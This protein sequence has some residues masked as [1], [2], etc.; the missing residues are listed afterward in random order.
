MLRGN[1]CIEQAFQPNRT[2]SSSTAKAFQ[3]SIQAKLSLPLLPLLEHLP[4]PTTKTKQQRCNAAGKLAIEYHNHVGFGVSK[5]TVPVAAHTQFVR[6][7]VT[8][9]LLGSVWWIF[10]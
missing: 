6:G 10:I 1:I 7:I 4:F 2:I 8:W 3:R 5:V 9:Y